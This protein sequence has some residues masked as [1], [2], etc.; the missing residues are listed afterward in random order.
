[1]ATLLTFERILADLRPG[2]ALEEADFGD[3]RFESL[4]GT[5]LAKAE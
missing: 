4:G 1:V 3:E 5:V 2:R